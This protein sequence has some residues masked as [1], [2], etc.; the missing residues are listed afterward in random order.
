[1]TS[2]ELV[3]RTLEFENRHDRAP[4]QMWTLPWAEWNHGNMIAKIRREYPDDITGT[5]GILRKRSIVSGDPYRKGVSRDAWGC[6]VTNIHEGIIGEVREPLVRGD[7]WEDA[8]LVH[9]PREWLT[10]DREQVNAFCRNTDRFVLSG[11]CPRPF[12]QLQFIRKTENLYS[13]WT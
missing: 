1:M 5:P 8:E 7:E 12:E 3:Y 4:R 13:I 2:R 9:I 11:C 10:F 6:M